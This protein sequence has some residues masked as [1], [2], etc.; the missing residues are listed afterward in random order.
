MI[1]VVH[2]GLFFLIIFKIEWIDIVFHPILRI[3]NSKK[4]LWKVI[5]YVLTFPPTEASG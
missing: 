5:Y 4:Y 1:V 2:A 3:L